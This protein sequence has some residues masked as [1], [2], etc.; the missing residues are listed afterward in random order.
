MTDTVRDD[1]E[2]EVVMVWND[3]L[4]LDGIE[5]FEPTDEMRATWRQTAARRR[6]AEALVRI[7]SG[8]HLSQAEVARR[9]DRDRAFVSRM[10]SATGSPPKQETI[11][12]YARACGMELGL[13]FR[14]LDGTRSAVAVR[15]QAPA[16]KA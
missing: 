2:T 4:D 7:R 6:L 8:A 15:T 9:M 13:V 10:E 3:D 14:P 12:A 1:A 11:A 16:A 5:G